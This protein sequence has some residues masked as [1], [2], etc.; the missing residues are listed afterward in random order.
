M[1][2]ALPAGKKMWIR[3]FYG[4]GPEGDGYVG[5]SQEAGRNHILK[6]IQD[7]DLIMIYGAGSVETEKTL[8]S[9]VLGFVQVDA[10]PIR[11]VDKSSEDSLAWKK[12]RGWQEK[13]TYGIP[14]RRA[15][16]VDEKVMISTIAFKTYRP[17]AGQAIGVW[18]AELQE[19]EIKQALKIKVSETSVFGEPPVTSDALTNSPF[20]EEFKPTRGF[21]GTSGKR[22]ASYQDGETFLY[23]AKYDGNAH[24]FLGKPKTFGP[25]PAAFKIGVSN[26]VKARMAQLNSGIPPAAK[27]R[28]VP[29]MEASFPDRKAAEN[30]EKLYKDNCKLESLGGEF[31]WGKAEDASK[32][33][34]SLPG[35]SRF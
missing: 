25:Q 21:P 3:A 31:F 33:F 5:W 23:L 6:H 35:V 32:A 2:S 13:W 29:E 28:W 10:T 1:S 7:G 18:G 4:F 22:E 8:R 15:W 16:R 17:E 20:G 11:D 34:R 24:A 19:E 26:D 9:H 12:S 30:A 14:V 27:A